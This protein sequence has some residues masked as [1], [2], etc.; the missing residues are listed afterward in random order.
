MK[1]LVLDSDPAAATEI[2]EAFQGSG[3]DVALAGN[4]A[5]AQFA[6][7]REFFEVLLIHVDGQDHSLVPYGLRMVGKYAHLKLGFLASDPAHISAD[8]SQH[9]QLGVIQKPLTPTKLALVLESAHMHAPGYNMNDVRQKMASGGF[10]AFNLVDVIQMCCISG[11]TGLLVVRSRGLSGDIYVQNGALVHAESPG[12]EGEEAVYEMLGWEDAQS[13][14]SEN[15][16]SPKTTLQIGWEHLLMEGVRRKDERL[17]GNDL[18]NDAGSEQLLGKMVGPF[19]VDRKIASDYWGTL[20]EAHQVA[21]SRPV[22]LK[23]LNPAFYGDGDRAQQFISFASAMARAQNPYIV[24]VYEAGQANGLIFY[25]REYVDGASLKERIRRGET[26]SEEAALRV[27]ANVAEA[28]N[29]EKEHGILHLPLLIDQILVPDTGVPKLFNNVT[30]EGGDVSPG[31]LDEIHRL[32]A[33]M[34]QTVSPED[35]TL[36]FQSLVQRMEQVEGEGFTDW[37]GVLEKV[38]HMELHR[39]AARA[40]ASISSGLITLGTTEPASR[41]WVKWVVGTA[42]AILLGAA[43]S[44]FAYWSER[45]PGA[46]DVDAMVEVPVGPFVYQNDKMGLPT[47]YVDKYEVTIG[48]Y[49]KFLEAWQK[50]R[51]SIEEHPKQR[52]GKDHTPAQWDLI[53]TAMEKKTKLNGVRVYDNTPV[54]NVDY[55]DAWAYAKW[56]GKRLPTEQE[57]EKAARGKDGFLYPW[58]NIPDPTKANTGADLSYSA[59][60]EAFGKID[61][62]GI[63]APVGA[64]PLDKSPFGAMDMAGNVSEWTESWD[65]NPDFPTEQVPVVRGGSWASTDVRLTNR[66]LRQAALK[67]SRQIGFRCVSDHPST[68]KPEAK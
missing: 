59:S 54:F 28:L 11:K 33:I 12:L 58:G 48:Q 49:Q 5:D 57:W 3:F 32:A 61:G 6:I 43:A 1:V 55:F 19:R 29:Y 52:P 64:K 51:A 36:E 65:T 35:L 22:A 40:D 30:M 62:F 60:D 16:R 26:L 50:N 14:L 21:V 17:E 63:W 9:S 20:Y 41:A 39:R 10:G 38:Q 23:V 4:Q 44:L 27:I 47:F 67:R 15:V 66:D 7:D 53:I 56:A 46:R 37:A 8:A 31:E 42:A 18:R 34:R 45:N 68:S 24:A 13:S 25:A 2:P